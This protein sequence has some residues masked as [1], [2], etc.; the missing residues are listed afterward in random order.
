[1]AA[2]FSTSA[3]TP[4]VF[5][6][7]WRTAGMASSAFIGS[8]FWGLKVSNGSHPSDKTYVKDLDNLIEVQ[9]PGSD[10]LFTF[11]RVET[12]GDRIQFIPLG[13]LPLNVCHCPAIEEIIVDGSK[14]T[15]LALALTMSIGLWPRARSD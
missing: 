1:M 14:H 8:S 5:A 7:S 6:T 13:Q 15:S 9:P 2:V 12:P 10:D 4:E 11:P 3:W